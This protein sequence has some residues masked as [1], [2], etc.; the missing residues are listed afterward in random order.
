MATTLRVDSLVC[1]GCGAAMEGGPVSAALKGLAGA[2]ARCRCGGT[3]FNAALTRT[4]EGKETSTAGDVAARMALGRAARFAID[5]SYTME[6][7]YALPGVPA[8]ELIE[9][10]GKPPEQAV[11]W[12]TARLKATAKANLR[13]DQKLCAECGEIFVI[14]RAAFLQAGFCS[15]MCLKKQHPEQAPGRPAAV[16]VVEKP[17]PKC[18][19]KVKVRPG[20]PCMWCGAALE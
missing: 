15:P 10:L 1:A 11:E 4:V 12:I 14:G 6:K 13:P 2:G 16:P 19:R 7:Q 9:N 5:R 17:C 20:K 8:A 3:T 18:G